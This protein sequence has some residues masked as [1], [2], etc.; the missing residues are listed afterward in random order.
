VGGYLSIG[1]A[2]PDGRECLS[3]AELT[4]VGAGAAGRTLVRALL[5]SGV[6]RVDYVD[7]SADSDDWNWALENERFSRHTDPD[8]RAL[9]TESTF[10][11]MAVDRPYPDIATALN[12][13]AHETA[14]P[15]TIGAVNGVDGQV[16][17]T[18][19][20]GETA[21]YDCFRQR[22]AAVTGAAYTRF[23]ESAGP[24]QAGMPALAMVVSGLLAADIVEQLAGGFGV[25]TGSIVGFDF[26]DFA[27]QADEVLRLPH[28]GTCGRDVDRLDAPR[29]VTVD[30]LARQTTETDR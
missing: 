10:A 29:H 13:T 19:Y 28:C 30:Y 24:E 14:T 8:L 15:W 5:D 22:A 16:G 4:V 27:V 12:E 9:V 11:A 20:P 25:T 21:C 1:D 18:V 6:G 17:P 2:D 26:D 23:E 7:L 3:L